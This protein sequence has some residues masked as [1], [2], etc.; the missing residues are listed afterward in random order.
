LKSLR[1]LWA[2]DDDSVG[3]DPEAPDSEEGTWDIQAY[4]GMYFLVSSDRCLSWDAQKKEAR[5][6]K[7]APQQAG[8]NCKWTIEVVNYSI[9]CSKGVLYRPKDDINCVEAGFNGDAKQVMALVDKTMEG[10]SKAWWKVKPVEAAPGKFEIISHKGELLGR[11]SDDTA[12]DPKTAGG[13]AKGVMAVVSSG[14]RHTTIDKKH[15]GCYQWTL[16]PSGVPNSFYILSHKGECLYPTKKEVTIGGKGSKVLT[17]MNLG[18]SNFTKCFGQ[19][20]Y[21]WTITEVA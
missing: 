8:E 7:V 5:M 2:G 12:C 4:G 20:Q 10:K 14:E 13:M 17:V 9:N 16:V 21:L 1:W 19:E 6:V 18:Y 3:A 11:A 15:R